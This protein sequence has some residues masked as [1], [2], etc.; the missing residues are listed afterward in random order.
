MRLPPY[1]LDIFLTNQD[2][3]LCDISFVD[4]VIVV[5]LVPGYHIIQELI[6][7]LKG[8]SSGLRNILLYHVQGNALGPK[9]FDALHC[10][11]VQLSGDFQP[12]TNLLQ[13]PVFQTPEQLGDLLRQR[14]QDVRLERVLC[15]YSITSCDSVVRYFSPGRLALASSSVSPYHLARY[16][17][18]AMIPALT[19]WR[20]RAL[21]CR[22]AS[23][24]SRIESP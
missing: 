17:Q 5:P 15:H 19:S 23:G 10:D 7:L 2:V 11:F 9:S 12:G 21:S 14:I 13:K 24:S 4:E 20:S 3:W 22:I 16:S 18:S 1:G 6:Q 8:N